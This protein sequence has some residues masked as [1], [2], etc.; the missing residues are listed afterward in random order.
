MNSMKLKI[1]NLSKT[2][3]NG[4]KALQDVSLPKSLNKLGR[5]IALH[6]LSMSG[7]A[8]ELLGLVP[9]RG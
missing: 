4:V 8:F 5:N 9:F 3:A 6:R 7:V 2:Y 1:D